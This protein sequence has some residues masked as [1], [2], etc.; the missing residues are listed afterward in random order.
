MHVAVLGTGTMGSG[1]A[2]TLLREGFEVSVWNRT[3]K[4][5]APHLLREAAAALT[6]SWMWSA[7]PSLKCV[8]ACSQKE[9]SSPV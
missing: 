2:R 1:V 8:L 7:W 9:E 5:A 6:L 4:K 3:A